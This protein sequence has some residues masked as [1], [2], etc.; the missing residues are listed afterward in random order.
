MGRGMVAIPGLINAHTHLGMTLFRGAADDLP[1]MTW[2]QEKVWPVE[3]RLTAEDVYWSSLLGIAEMLRG[4]V[5]TFADMYWFA[6]AVAD[7]VRE[8]GI[9]ACLSGVV[10]GIV[11]QA[12]AMLE[13]AIAQVKGFIAEGNPLIIPFFGPHAPYTVP[14][15][16]MQRVIAL[17]AELGV[18]IQTHLS[19]TM[20]EVKDCVREHGAGPIAVMN[21]LG[22]FSVP[23]TA[24][25]CVHPI[26]D[27][28]AILAERQVGVVHCP[29]SNMKLGSGIAPVPAFL[30]ADIIVGLGT[31]SAGSNNTLDILR[32][33]RGAALLQ[34]VNGDPTALSASE[35]LAL[36]TRGSAAALRLPYLGA[37]A[38]GKIADIALLNF[39]RPH[40][41]PRGRVVS[42]LVY[43][44]YAGD[45]D[46]V[47]VHGRILMRGR[48]LL[49]LDEERI[50]ARVNESAQRLFQS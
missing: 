28:M 48:R 13:K 7:A 9:R 20:N 41:T 36:A 26:D 23:V 45:V 24:A 4:G 30:D 16:M 21:Q 27:E 49:T 43:A 34:K 19:E 5:T 12:E 2:L 35:A 25:H 47:I 31:D 50:R 40:L 15:P 3:T 29:S 10:I 37:L 46:T 14:K 17:A 42:D 18:G 11:P 1:L 22:L 38:V 44:A 6:D 33:V 32:E 8:S 39:D